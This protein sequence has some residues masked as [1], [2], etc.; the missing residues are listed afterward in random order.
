MHA[1]W[2]EPT[3]GSSREGRRKKREMDIAGVNDQDPSQQLKQGK[4]AIDEFYHQNKELRRKLATKAMEVST[5]QGHEGNVAWL[6]RQLKDAQDTI[7]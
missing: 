2:L 5:T 6:K 4:L 3:R 7:V 1:I